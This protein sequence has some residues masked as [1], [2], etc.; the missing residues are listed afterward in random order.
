MTG[1]RCPQFRCRAG[2]LWDGFDGHE[3]KSV[4][5]L[6]REEY[7]KP[8][9]LARSAGLTLVPL[10]SVSLFLTPAL[11]AAGGEP[12]RSTCAARS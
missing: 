12:F 2:E 8:Q 6:Q 5:E 1:D 7:P 9:G 3:Y 10:I 11:S 4:R